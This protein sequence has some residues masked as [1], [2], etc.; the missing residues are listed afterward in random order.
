MGWEMWEMWWG[1]R[2]GDGM[3]WEM[4]WFFIWMDVDR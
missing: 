1:G 2:C 4:W 3:G